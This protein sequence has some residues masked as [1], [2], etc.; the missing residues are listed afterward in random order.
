MVDW[1][2][3]ADKA[4]HVV[5]KRGSANSLEEDAGEL[6]RGGCGRAGGYREGRRNAFGQSQ[7]AAK[8]IKEP[9]A[10]EQASAAAPS[11]ST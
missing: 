10:R 4:S 9:G 1:K 8:A 3:L 5:E 11:L 2:K 6:A 7:A